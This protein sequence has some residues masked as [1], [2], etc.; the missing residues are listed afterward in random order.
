MTGIAAANLPLIPFESPPYRSLVRPDSC[1]LDSASFDLLLLSQ[2]QQVNA[3]F[4][5]QTNRKTGP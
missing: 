5:P 3:G 1:A 2:C 4:N